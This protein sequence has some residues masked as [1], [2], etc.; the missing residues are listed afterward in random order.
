MFSTTFVFKIFIFSYFYKCDRK[1]SCADVPVYDATG[2]LIGW[3]AINDCQGKICRHK[4]RCAFRFIH[5]FGERQVYRQITHVWDGG[6][7][8]YTGSQLKKYNKRRSI[9]RRFRQSEVAAGRGSPIKR[10]RKKSYRDRIKKMVK[11][12]KRSYSS[13]TQCTCCSCWTKV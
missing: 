6:N 10:F 12:Y 13:R 7:D 9:T 11:P 1:G 5:S 8:Y 4:C 2:R 3:D